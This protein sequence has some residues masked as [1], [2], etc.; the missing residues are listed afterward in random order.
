MAASVLRLV[1][2]AGAVIEQDAS[3]APLW[4]LACRRRTMVLG[5]VRSLFM[6]TEVAPALCA[7]P[8]KASHSR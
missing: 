4:S 6:Q 5:P 7:R 3:Q 8:T 1:D 2:R